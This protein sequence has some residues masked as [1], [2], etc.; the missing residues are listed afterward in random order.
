MGAEV[1]MNEKLRAR[2]QTGA[3][4]LM[5]PDETVIYGVSSMT[6]LRT[7]WPACCSRRVTS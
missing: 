4:P 3:A 7:V 1:S 5:E 6:M 2:M